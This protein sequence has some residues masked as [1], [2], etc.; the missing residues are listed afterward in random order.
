[1]RVCVA[2]SFAP[3][4]GKAGHINARTH[5]HRPGVTVQL[6]VGVRVEGGVPRASVPSTLRRRGV[7][8]RRWRGVTRGKRAP[9]S[10]HSPKT[11]SV[12]VSLRRCAVCDDRRAWV[13]SIVFAAACIPVERRTVAR[14]G[15]APA[16]LGL[17]A[18]RVSGKSSVLGGTRGRESGQSTSVCI[19]LFLQ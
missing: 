16:T 4:K 5:A 1:M 6:N 8:A 14:R 11:A 12:A 15:R 7:R 9:C 17:A 19:H 2:A 13:G 3:S 10:V 18:A